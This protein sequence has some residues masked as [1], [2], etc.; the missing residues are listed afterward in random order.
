MHLPISS[1]SPSSLS[2][3]LPHNYVYL[4]LEISIHTASANGTF[5]LQ[6]ALAAQSKRV[7]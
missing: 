6:A 1:L 4:S 2:H 7:S 3:Y 5:F